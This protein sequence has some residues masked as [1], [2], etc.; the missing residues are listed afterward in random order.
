MRLER[1]GAWK[2]ACDEPKAFRVKGYRARWGQTAI[3]VCFIV[4]GTAIAAL[5]YHRAHIPDLE[6]YK[7]GDP[8]DWL[9][10]FKAQQL[11]P[12]RVESFFILGY[13]L[14]LSGFAWI[15]R[16][17]AASWFGRRMARYVFAAVIITAAAD[18]IK[19]YFLQL[20]LRCKPGSAWCSVFS[21]GIS[22]AAA[23]KWC[24]A[25]L[26]LGGMAAVVGLSGRG[27]TGLFRRYALPLIRKDMREKTSKGTL[28]YAFWCRR[29]SSGISL[30]RHQSQ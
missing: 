12:L 22:A 28:D 24:A 7:Y 29:G 14:V 19:D 13:S 30:S 15:Y 4:I 8:K 10:G 9:P 26:A 1:L 25:L 17:W 27:A 23:V 2:A 16:C 20:I 5:C 18:F 11:A 21:T 3:S 6:R